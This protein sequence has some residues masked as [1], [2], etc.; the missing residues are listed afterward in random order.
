MLPT[1]EDLS[2]NPAAPCKISQAC[3]CMP[4]MLASLWW[5]ETAG[6]QELAGEP[7]ST[8]TVL[9]THTQTYSQTL[10]HRLT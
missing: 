1:Y 7:A 10:R 3:L 8:Y 4:I 6:F 5:V 2:S 9:H